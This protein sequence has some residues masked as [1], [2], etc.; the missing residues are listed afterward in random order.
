MTIANVRRQQMTA[1]TMR[2]GTIFEK[3]ASHTAL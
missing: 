3:S 1:L 2:Q